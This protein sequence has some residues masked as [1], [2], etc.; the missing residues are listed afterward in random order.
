MWEGGLVHWWPEPPRI[1]HARTFFCSSHHNR[2]PPYSLQDEARVHRHILAIPVLK[3]SPAQGTVPFE[4]P[5]VCHLTYITSF[6][7]TPPR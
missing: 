2:A 4:A 6:N 5:T 3:E 7:I 1:R